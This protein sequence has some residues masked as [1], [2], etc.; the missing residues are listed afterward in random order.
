MSQARLTP[1]LGAAAAVA[2][3]LAAGVWLA[4]ALHGAGAPPDKAAPLH[5]VAMEA[6]PL[7][8]PVVRFGMP[9]SP[10]GSPA[11]ATL[12]REHTQV[13]RRPLLPYPRHSGR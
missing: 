10:A 11:V 12:V 2:A 3:A 1:M 9:L 7:P 6:P 4:L 5:A 13:S 8:A